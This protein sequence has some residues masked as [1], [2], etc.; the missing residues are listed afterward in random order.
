MTIM[1][2]AQRRRRSGGAMALALI[3]AC[4]AGI[5][6]AWDLPPSPRAY[7]LR[8][9]TDHDGRVSRAE[10]VAWMVRTF[11]ALDADHDGVLAGSELPAGSK[12]VARASY[13]QSLEAGFARQDRNHDGYLDARELALPPR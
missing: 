5:A 6:A 1:D 9:D 8:M 4:S 11:N 13:V 12:P 7:L 3:L 2:R 10:Y